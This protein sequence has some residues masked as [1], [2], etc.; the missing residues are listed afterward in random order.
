MTIMLLKISHSS[1]LQV[2]KGL[3]GSNQDRSQCL[4]PENSNMVQTQANDGVIVLDSTTK[5]MFRSKPKRS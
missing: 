5:K 3:L 2:C 1:D 4:S